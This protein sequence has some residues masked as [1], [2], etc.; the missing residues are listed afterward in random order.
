MARICKTEVTK[1]RLSCIY[2]SET[3]L[4][5]GLQIHALIYEF[6]MYAKCKFSYIYEPMHVQEN[7]MLLSS[8]LHDGCSVQL[9]IFKEQAV[10]CDIDRSGQSTMESEVLLCRM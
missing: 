10:S 1:Y 4:L 6:F 9:L 5:L 8:I 7:Y 2:V 3:K